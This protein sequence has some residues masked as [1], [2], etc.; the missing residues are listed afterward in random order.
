MLCFRIKEQLHL[1]ACCC[2]MLWIWQMHRTTDSRASIP[3]TIEAHVDSVKMNI[4]DMMNMQSRISL[5]PS[6]IRCISLFH[7]PQ[8]LKKILGKM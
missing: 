4:C 5:L 8:I 3:T 2:F 6:E 7:I 1:A